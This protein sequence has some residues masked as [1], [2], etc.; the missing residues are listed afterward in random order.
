MVLYRDSCRIRVGSQYRQPAVIRGHIL[1]ETGVEVMERARWMNAVIVEMM[2]NILDELGG[3][4]DVANGVVKLSDPFQIQVLL[5]RALDRIGVSQHFAFRLF[6]SFVVLFITRHITQ[7]LAGDFLAAWI[8]H[9]S[10]MNP[11]TVHV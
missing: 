2:P 1:T 10:S 9:G 11:E 8:E 3:I 4:G 7:R 6:E 5:G